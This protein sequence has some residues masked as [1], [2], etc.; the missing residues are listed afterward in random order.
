MF[1][2]TNRLRTE[3]GHGH[4]LEE[5]FGKRGGV[6]KQAGFRGFELWKKET[7]G[8][9]DEYLVVTQGPAVSKGVQRS[10]SPVD[11]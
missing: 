9:Y 1:V 2:S 3:R 11:W 7:E 6:E 4:K 8:D 10:P 5:R